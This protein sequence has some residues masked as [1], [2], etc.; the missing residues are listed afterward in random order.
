MYMNIYEYTYMYVYM[1]VYTCVYMNVYFILFFIN[2]VIFAIYFWKGVV[3]NDICI[4]SLPIRK[5]H[6]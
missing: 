1:N 2:N 4:M 5:F 3:I 6:F